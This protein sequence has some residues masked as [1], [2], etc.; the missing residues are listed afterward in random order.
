M[1]VL[2]PKMKKL[3]ALSQDRLFLIEMKIP[4]HLFSECYTVSEIV[5][6]AHTLRK[7]LQTASTS[8]CRLYVTDLVSSIHNLKAVL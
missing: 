6:L 2:G 4:L 1:K 5:D 7:S 8:P 3:K